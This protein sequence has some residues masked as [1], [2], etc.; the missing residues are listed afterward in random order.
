MGETT[1]AIP[2]QKAFEVWWKGGIASDFV[3]QA[4]TELEKISGPK[5]VAGT[6]PFGA[7]ATAVSAARRQ[8]DQALSIL[9]EANTLAGTNREE[10]S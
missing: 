4:L 10:T 9:R 7:E 5:L 8:L 1:N 6:G 2:K 3:Q